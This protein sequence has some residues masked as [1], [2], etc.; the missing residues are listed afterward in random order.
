MV[1]TM[2]EADLGSRGSEFG[3][4]KLHCDAGHGRRRQLVASSI[5]VAV[6]I[7]GA[8]LSSCGQ[9][10]T[11]GAPI[12]SPPTFDREPLTAPEGWEPMAKSPLSG[13]ARPVTAW[14]GSE[15]LI[16]R[17]DGAFS[18]GGGGEPGRT[19]GAAYDPHTNSWRAMADSPMPPPP[20]ALGASDY[21][22]AWTGRE[23]LVW[24]GPGP[25]AAA[26]NPTM[27]SWRQIDAG[28]LRSRTQFASV[29][30]GTELVIAGGAVPLAESVDNPDPAV[31]QQAAAYDPTT[32]TWRK[33]PDLEVRRSAQAVW[34]GTEILLLAD[35]RDGKG[36]PGLGFALDPEDTSPSWRRIAE[37]PLARFDAPPV[38]T[39]SEVVAVGAATRSEPDQPN[40]PATHA[41][42][43]TYDPADDRWTT[44]PQPAG[45]RVDRLLSPTTVWT[46]REV[47]LL[48]A[49]RFAE[50]DDEGVE[51]A[52]F[53]PTTRTWRTLPA[54]ALSGR[55]G[56]ASG[57]TGTELIIWGG[58]YY[59][60]YTSEP[61]TDG[62]RYRPGP[63]R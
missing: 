5:A 10:V 52:A 15:L 33:L 32:D 63:G 46:G 45:L 56:M 28:P 29:W 19:G 2:R 17:G 59:S 6:I 43:A 39:G 14:T 62:S 8:V 48:G 38:W 54:P 1:A 11:D 35:S 21:A 31:A 51:G 3:A 30:T 49:P 55:G 12:G 41:G 22:S 23:L 9:D 57:W 13:R 26:Y 16:W 50:P 24:G 20:N 4:V 25:D 42:V 27:D 58:A 37:P 53:D 34:T 36:S 18:D 61:E 47:L 44:A 7:A 60:G 40:E